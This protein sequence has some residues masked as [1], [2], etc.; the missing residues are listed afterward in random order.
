MKLL[1]GEGGRRM[2]K[3]RR[4]DGEWNVMRDEGLYLVSCIFSSSFFCCLEL[5]FETVELVAYEEAFF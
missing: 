1:P 2:G 5:A 3:A 4:L